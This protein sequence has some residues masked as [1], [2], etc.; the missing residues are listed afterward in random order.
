[1]LWCCYSYPQ[2][3][4]SFKFLLQCSATTRFLVEGLEYLTFSRSCVSVSHGHFLSLCSCFYPDDRMLLLVI[5]GKVL[6]EGMDISLFPRYASTTSKLGI[7][8]LPATSGEL[9]HVFPASNLF[10][11]H[12]VEASI[13]VCLGCFWLFYSFL[14]NSDK[15]GNEFRSRGDTKEGSD[16]VGVRIGSSSVSFTPTPGVISLKETDCHVPEWVAESS[17]VPV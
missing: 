16:G 8:S 2:C 1:M 3:I 10:C 9:S 6:G 11:E 5:Q 17:N 4:T 13:F 15:S 12:L 14:K 7:P